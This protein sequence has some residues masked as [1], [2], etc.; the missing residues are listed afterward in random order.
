MASG[1][2]TNSPS[3]PKRAPCSPAPWAPQPRLT[4]SRLLPLKPRPRRRPCSSAPRVSER[5][6]SCGARSPSAPP[7]VSPE[8]KNVHR[9]LWPRGPRAPSRSPGPTSPV[10]P[11]H[12]P[13]SSRPAFPEVDLV[14]TLQVRGAGA[15]GAGAR[16]RE[17]LLATGAPR[18][19][20]V[21][22]VAHQRF[23][24]RLPPLP[25]APALGGFRSRIRFGALGEVLA[26]PSP[27]RAKVTRKPLLART[28]REGPGD[29][30]TDGLGL[31]ATRAASPAPSH[32][33]RDR[34][35]PEAPGARCPPGSP[36]TR[37]GSGFWESATSTH[38]RG[39]EP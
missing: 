37:P 1:T 17:L 27:S 20:H 5:L 38:P 11:R 9:R 14:P 29:Q 35:R 24:R 23:P 28:E 36:S 8:A 13:H 21:S 16:G 34:A 2:L 39:S 19:L 26:P 12:T 3:E 25:P 6:P 22:R 7:G 32:F 10:L 31:P 15:R 30:C 33:L 18:P 4:D